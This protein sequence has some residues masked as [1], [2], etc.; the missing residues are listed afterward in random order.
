MQYNIQIN[1]IN[2]FICVKRRIFIRFPPLFRNERLADA[3]IFKIGLFRLL[4]PT[5]CRYC[6]DMCVYARAR[7]YVYFMHK[8]V[9]VVKLY[10]RLS[11][12]IFVSSPVSTRLKIKRLVFLLV[13]Y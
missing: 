12:F 10:S 7:A 9:F 5:Q 6:V 8:N 11:F 4:S 2:R 3:I 13:N 1:Q